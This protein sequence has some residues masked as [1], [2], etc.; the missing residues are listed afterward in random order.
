MKKSKMATLAPI[1]FI[2]IISLVANHFSLLTINAQTGWVKQS[3]LP[4]GNLLRSSDF[5]NT[6]TGIAVGNF[7]TIVKTTNQ[8]NTWTTKTSGTDKNL[9]HVCFINQNTGFVA[10]IINGY[11]KTTNSGENWE[12]IYLGNNQTPGKFFFVNENIGY[13]IGGNSLVM[14]TLNGGNNWQNISFNNVLYSAIFFANEQTGYIAGVNSKIFKTTNGGINWQQQQSAELIAIY[15][16]DFINKDTGFIAGS[17]F[18][19][20]I[21]QK[22]TNGGINWYLVSIAGGSLQ[23]IKF[24]DKETGYA[25]GREILKSTDGGENWFIINI[26]HWMYSNI[27]PVDEQIVYVF[28]GGIRKTTNGGDNWFYQSSGTGTD[29][30]AIYML[31]ENTGYIGGVLKTTNGGINW[32]ITPQTVAAESIYF[33]NTYTGFAVHDI[34]FYKTINGGDNWEETIV[35][36][37]LYSVVFID[38]NTGFVAGSGKIL[39]TTNSGITWETKL[40]NG[41]YTV[42]FI[43]AQTGYAT[44]YSAGILK[45]SDGGENWITQNIPTTE[46]LKSIIFLNGNTGFAAGGNYGIILKT[47]NGGMNWLVSFQSS[48]VQTLNAVYF[49]NINTG[50][51]VGDYPSTVLKTTN[52]GINWNSQNTGSTD[53]FFCVQFLN[54]SVGYVAGKWGIILKTTTAGEPIGIT[55]ISS[56]IPSDFRLYQNYPNPFNPMTTIKFEIPSSKSARGFHT[57]LGVYDILGRKISILVSEELYPGSYEV[58]WNGYNYPSGVYFCRLISDKL[59][60]TKKMVLLK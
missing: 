7:G 37:S 54:D 30:K 34:K 20:G 50:Y 35:G 55:K 18:G 21:I 41:G 12:Q 14:K 33:L 57:S 24:A 40:S 43:N 29:M 46:E 1:L 16:M 52:G 10:G 45:T 25:I 39:K 51:A 23:K 2:L 8:G 53:G 60:I 36:N 19:S 48:T 58:S 59:F 38:Y 28:G 31:N 5:I 42:Y 47:T 22:T 17:L 56:V 26:D 11:L 27:F 6:N 3:P 9:Y 32:L 13:L 49:P 44:N 15:S 4:T